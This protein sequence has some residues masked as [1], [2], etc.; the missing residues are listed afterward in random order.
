MK[1]PLK[2]GGR[3]NALSD[4]EKE[5]LRNQY[6][7]DVD[8]QGSALGLSKRMKGNWKELAK[9]FKDELKEIKQGIA[10]LGKSR[11]EFAKKS[12][13]QRAEKEARKE[14]EKQ[15]KEAN[16]QNKQQTSS[17]KS[18]KPWELQAERAFERFKESYQTLQL[19]QAMRSDFALLL[20]YEVAIKKQIQAQQV[21]A[22]TSRFGDLVQEIRDI[23]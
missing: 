2:K 23:A 9:S 18:K 14:Q 16:K 8:L 1:N 12:K 6:G 7:L 10:E 5:L 20:D 17:E 4:Y 19:N 3:A 11:E 22:L 15:A 21:L 13:E